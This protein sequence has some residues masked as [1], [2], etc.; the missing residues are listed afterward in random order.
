MTGNFLCSLHKENQHNKTVKNDNCKKWIAITI[1]GFADQN[2]LIRYLKKSEYS[3]KE[4]M[5][6]DDPDIM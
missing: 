4:C 2:I 1:V 3:F 6:V 5:L